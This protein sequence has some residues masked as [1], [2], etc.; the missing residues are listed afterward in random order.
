M[1]CS[2]KEAGLILAHRDRDERDGL[3]PRGALQAALLI[4]AGA[5]LTRLTE[6]I[7]EGQDR[8]ERIR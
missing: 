8:A 6:W 7:I 4:P 1:F 2:P 5:D 3:W